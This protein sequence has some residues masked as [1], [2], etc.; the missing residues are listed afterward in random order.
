MAYT[1]Q[2]IGGK[3]SGLT[4]EIEQLTGAIEVPGTLDDGTLGQFI[5]YRQPTITP[6]KDGGVV[7]YAPERRCHP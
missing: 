1:A 3:H 2:I 5:Y 7:F 6:V 4:F